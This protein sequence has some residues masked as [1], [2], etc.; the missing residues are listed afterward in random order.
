MPILDIDRRHLTVPGQPTVLDIATTP[1]DTTLQPG[2]RLRVNIFAAN[3][4][5][6]SRHARTGH[7]GTLDSNFQLITNFSAGTGRDKRVAPGAGRSLESVLRQRVWDIRGRQAAGRDLAGVALPNF[8]GQVPTT[9][10]GPRRLEISISF[11]T[12]FAPTG[13]PR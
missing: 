12:G 6:T 5:E 4:F 13:D 1:I 3:F 8:P 9:E 11:S 7:A 10:R 2:H